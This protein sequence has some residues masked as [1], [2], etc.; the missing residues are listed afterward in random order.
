MKDL[1]NLTDAQRDQATPPYCWL[2]IA[3]VWIVSA[4]V[5]LFSGEMLTLLIIGIAAKLMGLW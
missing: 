3:I 1:R 4:A 5:V 2:Q